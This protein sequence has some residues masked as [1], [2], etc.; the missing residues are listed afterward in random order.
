MPVIIAGLRVTTVASISLVTVG[1][2]IGIGGLGQ[3][4]TAGENTDFITE[5]I[6]GIVLVAFWALVFDGLLLAEPGACWPRGPGGRRDR[7]RR[8]PP[9]AGCWSYLTTAA[10][11]SG[12]TGFRTAWSSTSGTRS[13]RMLIAVRHRPS[14]RADHRPHRPGRGACCPC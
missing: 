9:S 3:L 5:I 2:L 6:A 13:R 8:P 11:W 4:F 10:N 1:S 14:P 12:P 7:R